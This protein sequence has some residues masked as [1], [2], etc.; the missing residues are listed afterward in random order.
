MTQILNGN[1]PSPLGGAEEKK[2]TVIVKELRAVRVDSKGIISQVEAEGLWSGRLP[3]LSH[4]LSEDVG[5]VARD[6]GE[7]RSSLSYNTSSNLSL[8]VAVRPW[9]SSVILKLD[10]DCC[11]GPKELNRR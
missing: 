4:Y 8:A 11:S 7:A 10:G 5:D 2:S 6:G 1:L 9:G 3:L